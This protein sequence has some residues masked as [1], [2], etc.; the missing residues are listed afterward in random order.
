LSMV[1]VGTRR[2]TTLL[3]QPFRRATTTRPDLAPVDRWLES[4]RACCH[5]VR[6]RVSATNSTS[7]APPRA[8][9]RGCFFVCWLEL[10]RTCW[11]PAFSNGDPSVATAEKADNLC[12]EHAPAH[13]CHSL[14][15]FSRNGFAVKFWVGIGLAACAKRTLA[16][17]TSSRRIGL[18]AR[19]RHPAA[20]ARQPQRTC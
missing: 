4:D 3:D 5:F 12:D 20:G 9:M 7:Q 6:R 19:E 1:S 11:R 15:R 18:G 16:E 14:T 13:R 17:R 8:Q 2:R 10:D